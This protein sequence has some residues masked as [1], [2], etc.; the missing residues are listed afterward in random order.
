MRLATERRV[1]QDH[2]GMVG[3]GLPTSNMMH[4]ILTGT[5][6]KLGFEDV[7][8]LPQHRPLFVKHLQDPHASMERK[9]HM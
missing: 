6:M 4:E 2:S 9:L 7:L 5:D 1:A 3:A 8:N